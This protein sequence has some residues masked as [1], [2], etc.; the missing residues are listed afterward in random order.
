MAGKRVNEKRIGSGQFLTDADVTGPM[1]RVMEAGGVITPLKTAAGW[2]LFSESDVVAARRWKQQ[3]AD[4]R[5]ARKAA[6]QEALKA[7]RR[8][9]CRTRLPT[10][11]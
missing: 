1:M 5:A 10:I 2:R 7:K 3:Q 11:S 9:S 4:E 8:V 6:R